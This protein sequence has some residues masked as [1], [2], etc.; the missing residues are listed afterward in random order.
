MY[1]QLLHALLHRPRQANKYDFGHVLVVGGSPG[2][3][4]APYLAGLAALR[5]GAGLVT[6]ASTVEVIDKLEDRTAELL[7]L[8]LPHTI[9]EAAARIEV[10]A[11]QRHVTVVALGPG[12]SANFAK[13][14]RE[15]VVSLDLPLVL[16]ASAVTTFQDSLDD[17]KQTKNDVVLTP[18]SGEFE[19]LTGEKLSDS[20]EARQKTAAVFARRHG[21]VMVAKGNP[22]LVVRPD[23]HVYVNTTGGPALATA[24]TGDVLTGMIAALVAQSLPA[25]QAAELAVYVHGKAGEL[26]AQKKTEPGV[27]ASDVIN[28]ISSAFKQGS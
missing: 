16:D 11:R 15:L 23:G 18:H 10:Y 8:R 20:E 2:M 5:T 19:I 4:G 1:K 9:K 28:E 14:A 12:M 3:V 13:L 7:T 6:V 22:T 26:A 25:A 21:V 27:I 17:F 24:G